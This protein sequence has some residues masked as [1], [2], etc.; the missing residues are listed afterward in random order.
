MV[1]IRKY[2]E[3]YERIVGELKANSQI[4]A[5]VVYGSIISGDIWD[6]S[7]IDVLAITRESGKFESIYT[8]VSGIQVH[9]NYVSRD[10]FIDSY[11]NLLK[12]GSFHK[13]FFTG[14][15]VYSSDRDLDDIYLST[16]FY[17]DKD[18]N[19]RNV[20]FLANLL[21]SMH[22]TK[23]YLSTGK[24]ETSYQW[25]VEMLTSY[26]R[27]LMNIEGHITDKDIL[28]YAVSMKDEVKH[29]F[30]ILTGEN[31]IGQRVQE[32]LDY[33]KRF[34][35]VNLKTISIPVIDFLN[36]R[37]RPVSLEDIKSSKVFKQIDA[38][39]NLLL[40]ELCK[41]KIIYEGTRK[42]TSYGDEYLVNEIVYYI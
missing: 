7:D 19:I 41:N 36:E 14:K 35:Q 29:L 10:S 17:G 25:C 9:I 12:G 32:I 8:K 22:Y 40:S 13:A 3:A 34:L 11:K 4:A 21:N 39:L 18:R 2:Q 23:K 15:L 5:I 37:K 33:I 27:L 30:S 24:L 26:S 1:D 42:Y 20:E 38:D 16:R 6:E 31:P 28:S